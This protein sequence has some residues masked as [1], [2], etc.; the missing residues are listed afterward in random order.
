V[1]KKKSEE[2]M[3]KEEGVVVIEEVVSEAPEEP[4]S[5]SFDEIEEL[6]V[7][8]SA[9]E[10]SYS[11]LE[12]MI[13]KGQEIAVEKEPR[14]KEEW[15]HIEW[16]RIGFGKNQLKWETVIPREDD[17]FMYNQTHVDVYQGKR[18]VVPDCIAREIRAREAR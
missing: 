13:T 12:G 18:M 4:P 17:Q 1:A 2:L 8:V 11:I 16:V 14:S 15:S 10:D 5:V 3:E 9:L 7:R 6:R